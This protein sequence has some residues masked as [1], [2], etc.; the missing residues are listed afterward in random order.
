MRQV[1]KIEKKVMAREKLKRPAYEGEKI[2][3]K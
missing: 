1:T 2:Q 3:A